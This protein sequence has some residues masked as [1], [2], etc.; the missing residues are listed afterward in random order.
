MK[1]L[2]LV[3]LLPF[4]AAVAQAADPAVTERYNRSC[5]LCHVTG[6]ANAPKTGVTADWGPRLQKGMGALIQSVENGLNAMPPKG[7]CMDCSAEDFKAL[8]EHMATAK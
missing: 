1:K 6:A 5:A 4:A 7:M 3:A 2:M 8:I